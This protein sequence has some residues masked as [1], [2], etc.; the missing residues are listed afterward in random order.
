[1]SNVTH[2][3]NSPVPCSYRSYKAISLIERR[4]LAV[5]HYQV[6]LQCC[7]EGISCN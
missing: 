1:M 3:D 5:V 2:G 4:N 7:H 6:G